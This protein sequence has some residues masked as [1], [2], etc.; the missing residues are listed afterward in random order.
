MT[1]TTAA[2]SPQQQTK[3]QP[4]AQRQE[5]VAGIGFMFPALL[6]LVLFL[7]VPLFVAGYFSL[8]DWNGRTPLTNPGAYDFVGLQNYERLLIS[9]R[10]VSDF[11][12]AFKNTFYYALGVIPTQTAIALVLAVIVNQRWL[13]GRSFFRTAFY[14]PSITSS[15]VVSMIFLFMFSNTG[16]VNGALRLI[17]PGFRDVSWITDNSG[18]LHN[19]VGIFGITAD[20]V[21]FLRDTEIFRIS[22]WEWLSGPSVAMFTIMILA[23]WT[24]IG[25]MMVVYLAA[26]QNIPSQVYEAAQV[27]GA[28]AWQTFRKITLPLLKPTT[29]FVVTLGLIGTFQVFDQ[30]YILQSNVTRETTMSIAYLVYDQAFETDPNMGRATAVAITLF[31]II[32]IATILQR[33]FV[34]GDRSDV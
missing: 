27:D 12:N 18:V 9:G 15:I 4:N 31:V 11:Y 2:A 26:L 17:I 34:G 1:T 24:T 7:I 20:S 23:I 10:R 13:R 5:A 6:I 19:I 29:F 21:P 32:F 30:I 3:T 33:R 14:F 8:T 25:T 28:T 16:P 22:L